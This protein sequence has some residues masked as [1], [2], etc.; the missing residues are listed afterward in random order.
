MLGVFSAL[1]ISASGL[2]AERVRMNTIASNLANVHTTKTAEG[3][4]YKRLDPV[5]EAVGLQSINEP[6][7]ADSGV[8]M[9]NV[10]NIQADKRPGT[11]VYEPGNPDANGQGYVEYPNVNAVEEMVNMITA[12][13]AYEA[14]ITSIDS[15]KAMAHSALGIAK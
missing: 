1:E 14:G 4:P 6:Y 8:S 11:M 7:S 5:F 13:R 15:V 2:G 3:G 10:K 9:V 12:S